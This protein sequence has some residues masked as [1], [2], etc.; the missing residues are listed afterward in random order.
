MGDFINGILASTLW[1]QT[2][3]VMGWPIWGLLFTLFGWISRPLYHSIKTRGQRRFWKPFIKGK[4]PLSVVLTD[5]VGLKQRSPAKISITDVQA[6]SDVRSAMS[7]FREVVI[8]AGSTVVMEDL[9]SDSFVT[10]GGPRAN[11]VTEQVL[12]RLRE[13][14]PVRYNQ[15]DEENGVFQFNNEIYEA[16]YDAAGFVIRDYALILRILKLDSGNS[17]S[18]AVLVAFGLHGHGT[19]Q[20]VRAITD[21]DPLYEEMS[22]NFASDCWAF[23]RFDF[24]NHSCTGRSV[25]ASGKLS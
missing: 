24:N 15:Q 22:P 20:A 21:F 25:V 1:S 11:G 9:T 16:R 6:Y 14:V 7:D 13:R 3:A 8:K 17:K 19:G 2:G 4:S 18:K 5:K 10:L 12:H 23:L